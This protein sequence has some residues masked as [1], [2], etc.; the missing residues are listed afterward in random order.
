MAAPAA[1]AA[2]SGGG[3]GAQ[4]AGAIIPPLITGGM[5]LLGGMLSN[6]YNEDMMVHNQNFQREVL[7]NQ[8]QWRKND[9]E[10]AGIHPVYAMGAGTASTFPIALDDHM[11]PA[12]RDMGQS[13][14]GAVS[15]I[16][17]REAREK[18]QLDMALGAA[19]LEE[20]DARKQMYL[21]EAARNR[22]VP[23]APMPGLGVQK[24]TPGEVRG[25]FEG[26]GQD[27]GIPGTGAIDLKPS[28]Q[29]SS[30]EGNPDV[31][32][33]VHPGY[34]ERNFRG[35][36]MLFPQTAGESPEEIVS[37]MSLPA[38]IG[39]LMLNQRTYGGNWLEDFMKLR[40]LGRA[41]EEKYP[42]LLEQQSLTKSWQKKGQVER[43]LEGVTGVKRLPPF[44]WEGRK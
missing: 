23:A 19:Q 11:G 26:F 5:S 18:H 9:A 7:S 3:G 2:A 38:Y 14:G 30:K 10:R 27:A 17:D 25:S 32:A 36:P 44:R 34:E 43:M 8:L 24:E 20:S 42:T 16:L 29:I 12:L 40:Y 4:V 39:L 28:E 6:E 21:S 15:R 31:T 41:P 37:E 35:M 1:A 22:Q 13:V 33:G